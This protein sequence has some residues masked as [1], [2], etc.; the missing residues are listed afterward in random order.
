MHGGS[1]RIASDKSQ[2]HFHGGFPALNVRHGL[3]RFG[4]FACS[5]P[6]ELSAGPDR[7]GTCW[8]KTRAAAS[9][10]LPSGD[11]AWP[12]ST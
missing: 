11:Q 10:A 5:A 2:C 12:A 3:E 9:L 6:A 7:S 4:W 8:S 1:R